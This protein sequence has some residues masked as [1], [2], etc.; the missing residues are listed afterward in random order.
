M[1]SCGAVRSQVEKCSLGRKGEIAGGEERPKV[2]K[3][4]SWWRGAIAGARERW[5]VEGSDR[6]WSLRGVIAGGEERSQVEGSGAI[7]GG[8]DWF[9]V[10]RGRQRWRGVIDGGG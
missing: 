10:D 3:R 6:W 9:Y 8:G 1:V 7:A 4:D 5:M 2:E